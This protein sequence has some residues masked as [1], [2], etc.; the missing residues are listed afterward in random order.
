MRSDFCRFASALRLF[1]VV[2]L[3]IIRSYGACTPSLTVGLLPRQR[4]GLNASH[5]IIQPDVLALLRLAIEQLDFI[6]RDFLADCDAIGNAD[7][8]RVLELYAGA[9]VSI[10]EQNFQTGGLQIL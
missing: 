3:Q 2:V 6:I 1:L 7:Q 10:I 9:F 4:D 5:N 8:V